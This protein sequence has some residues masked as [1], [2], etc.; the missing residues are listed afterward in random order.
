[1]FLF[2]GQFVNRPYG[3]IVAATIGRHKDDIGR[4]FKI[5]GEGLLL[6][7]ISLPQSTLQVDSSLVRG[8]LFWCERCEQPKCRGRLSASRKMIP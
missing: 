8:S 2:C 5:V 1:M 3:G 4:K 6:L 7:P